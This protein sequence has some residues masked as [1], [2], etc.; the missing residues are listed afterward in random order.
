MT[1]AQFKEASWDWVQN[2]PDTTAATATWGDIGDWDVS[3]V[4]DFRAA[5]SKFRSEAGG[6]A[7]GSNPNAVKFFG[8]GL[9]KWKTTSATSLYATFRK[10]SEFNADLSAWD[11]SRVTILQE[12]FQDASKFDA[13]GL[14]K[15]NTAKVK[16]LYATFSG[17]AEMNADLGAWDLANVGRLDSVFYTATKYT[18]T[19][20][21]KWNV[22]KVVHMTSA[23]RGASKFIGT[24]LDKWNTASVTS[25]E[26]TFRD[27]TAMNADLSGWFVD[28]VVIGKYTSMETTFKEA[29]SLSS[30]NK[31]KIADAWA[32]NLA[33]KATSYTADWTADACPIVVRSAM[34]YRLYHSQIIDMHVNEQTN[35]SLPSGP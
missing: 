24:G 27:A 15:W 33:F 11:V 20:I 1:E 35:T 4:V 26:A 7:S 23:F 9:S 19:G 21:H 18:G 29:S 34:I 17:L 5:F 22:V 6:S 28:K 25:L 32:G 30:C 3:G 2:L 12:T 8:I 14:G 31:R 13:T 16:S 10:A